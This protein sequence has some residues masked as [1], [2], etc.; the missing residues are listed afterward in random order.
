MTK[1]TNYTNTITDL[2]EKIPSTQPTKPKLF[3]SP[4]WCLTVVGIIPVVITDWVL[5]LRKHPVVTSRPQIPSVKLLGDLVVHDH[6][7]GGL[8]SSVPVVPLNGTVLPPLPVPTTFNVTSPIDS[9]RTEDF[10]KVDYDTPKN[11]YALE[12]VQHAEWAIAKHETTKTKETGLNQ[13][14][15]MSQDIDHV[16]KTIHIP[17]VS[18]ACR[19]L[20]PMLEDARRHF[21]CRTN[22]RL[23]RSEIN[24]FFG[25]HMLPKVM[26]HLS[27]NTKFVVGDLAL[28][29][30]ACEVIYM[31]L[32]I[33]HRTLPAY[34]LT[35]DHELDGVESV[36]EAV[37][38]PKI[39]HS[40][41]GE[42]WELT[43]RF[44][45]K[46]NLPFSRWLFQFPTP[47]LSTTV[48]I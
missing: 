42:K 20:T 10:V 35:V 39:W 41:S 11:L 30:T 19:E 5:K 33:T 44:I 29:Y 43:G 2:R 45:K 6:D 38:N 15:V 17:T 1:N 26:S 25:R 27:S 34:H 22:V 14:K 48:A 40:Y 32:K 23:S 9:K 18:L 21:V 37:R 7:K 31:F 16:S 24:Y 12:T 47:E 36:L 4:W 8:K 46:K 13:V 3:M 28:Q